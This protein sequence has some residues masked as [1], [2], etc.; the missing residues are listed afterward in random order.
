M[1]LDVNLL[2]L[3]EKHGPKNPLPGCNLGPKFSGSDWSL[4][5]KKMRTELSSMKIEHGLCNPTYIL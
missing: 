4:V 1:E 5:R 3:K 2:R